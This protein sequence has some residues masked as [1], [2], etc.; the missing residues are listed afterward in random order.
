MAKVVL[1]DD[2]MTIVQM[3]G[4]LLRSEG[5]Q[6]IPFTQGSAAVENLPKV[7]PELVIANLGLD[8]T[9]AGSLALLQKSRSLQPPALVIMITPSGSIEST[10]EA[11]K[12][13]AY[14]YL[15]KPFSLDELKLRVQR[16][17]SYHA[18]IS[19]NDSLRKQLGSKSHF[20]DIIGVSP[21]M[22]EIIGL[23]ERIA[24][25]DGSVTLVGES[26]TGKE[27]I[28]RAIHYNS[29]RRFAPFIP[30]GCGA[31]PEAQL[32]VEFFGQKKAPLANGADEP[33]GLLRE[34]H[35][36][37]IFLKD[38]SSLS[39][40]LQSRLLRVIE[41]RQIRLPGDALPI[42]IDVRMLASSE[43]P[44]QSKVSD[45]TLLGELHQRLAE[46][47]LV[48]PPL[49]ER[50]E[51]IPLFIAHFLD[52]KIHPRGGKGYTISSEAIEVCTS[53]AWPGN[54]QELENA[55][56]HA[57]VVCKDNV[58]QPCDLPRA[59]QQLRPA[60]EPARGAS[61]EN[62]NAA[63]LARAAASIPGQPLLAG[64]LPSAGRQLATTELVPLKKYLRDQEINYLHQTLAMVG[65]SKERAAELLR[66]SLATMYRKLSEPGAEPDAL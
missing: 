26:G 23:I 46:L 49:R 56:A 25:S 10:L 64:D 35:G 33:L 17:L 63:I 51:D 44:L 8:K 1:V 42:C 12:R 40:A 47:T 39:S 19:E 59:V 60:V 14:D 43:E 48:L 53:Y 24:A 27:L 32:E 28:A 2:E 18:A 29:R 61:D 66:I 5:H 41:E 15:V 34:A 62:G 31:L 57:R 30:I 58:I 6:V 7:A 11:I 37:T 9:R 21:R 22:Q 55:L 54:V 3:V 45:G 4:E 52:G 13:G 38:L 65:G 16:A 50:V 20:S 36:G